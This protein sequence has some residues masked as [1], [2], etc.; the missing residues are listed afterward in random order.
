MYFKVLCTSSFRIV[1]LTRRRLNQENMC[2]DGV[3]LQVGPGPVNFLDGCKCSWA[4]GKLSEIVQGCGG[5]DPAEVLPLVPSRAIYCENAGERRVLRERVA[6]H[7]L[8]R[9]CQ[10]G[11][12][13]EANDVRHKEYKRHLAKQRPTVKRPERHCERLQAPRRPHIFSQIPPPHRTVG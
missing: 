7:A 11:T 8:S 6:S 1:M 4:T 2:R 13:D 9:R 5:C 3:F 12:A 10:I